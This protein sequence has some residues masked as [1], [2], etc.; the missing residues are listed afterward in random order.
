MNKTS[1]A[2]MK[3]MRAL[4]DETKLPKWAQ[5]L[6]KAE[7]ARYARLASEHG[8]L[9]EVHVLL[10]EHEWF[11]LPGPPPDDV[12]DYYTLY[13][14]RE[15]RAVAVCSIGRGDRLF[16]GRARKAE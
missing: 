13:I 12:L 4:H 8:R 14:F 5:E 10:N 16:V 2:A 3:R 9:R 11:S 15:N 6:L 1:K 7:R